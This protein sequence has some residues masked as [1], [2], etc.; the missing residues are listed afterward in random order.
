VAE[1]FEMLVRDRPHRG[2]RA[3][4]DARTEI[5]RWSG[6]MFRSADCRRVFERTG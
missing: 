2:A 5:Q 4:A 6:R 3:F 1:T